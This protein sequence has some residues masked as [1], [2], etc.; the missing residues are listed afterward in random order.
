MKKNTR[1]KGT[2]LDKLSNFLDKGCCFFLKGVVTAQQR[3]VD[4]RLRGQR[5]GT[6]PQH[7]HLLVGSFELVI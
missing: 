4:Q 7:F 5:H 6:E 2:S 3:R 1:R